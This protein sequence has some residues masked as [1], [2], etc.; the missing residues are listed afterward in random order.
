M[1]PFVVEPRP[2]TYAG[3]W[4]RFLAYIID[5]ILLWVVSAILLVPLFGMLGLGELGGF[6][7]EDLTSSMGFLITLLSTYI[8]TIFAMMIAGW[9]YFALMESSSRGATL[10]KIVLRIHVTDMEGN[11]ISFGRASGRYFGKILSGLIFYIGFIMAGFTQQKQA[12]H[13]ILAGC[14]VV[15][16]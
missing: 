10:G 6:L 15:N 14:L 2:T 8:A 1:E 3:F 16:D 4:K 7:D 9:L 11:N 13:D 5:G 12:L